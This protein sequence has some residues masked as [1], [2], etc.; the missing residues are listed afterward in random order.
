MN[1]LYFDTTE[2]KFKSRDYM[3]ELTLNGSS[4][5][6]YVSESD[7]NST[8]TR[9]LENNATVHSITAF[10]LSE[11]EAV[12]LEEINNSFTDKTKNTYITYTDELCTFV[13]YGYVDPSSKLTKL[14]EISKKYIQTYRTKF[15]EDIGNILG[16]VRKLKEYGGIKTSLGFVETDVVSQGK[17]SALYQA[18]QVPDLLEKTTPFKMGDGTFSELTKEDIDA[19]YTKVAK[20]IQS[21]FNAENRSL[22]QIKQLDDD[23]LVAMW[24]DSTKIEE[25][26]YNN[27]K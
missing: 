27:F 24:K 15:V 6:Y 11:E 5:T 10:K 21:C 7:K 1:F 26:F 3:L 14:K 18:N 19:L 20:L 22:N 25:I 8:I 9:F 4:S 12:R 23:S 13:V 17:I 2:N 16:T